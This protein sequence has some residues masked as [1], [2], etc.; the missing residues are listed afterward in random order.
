L[1]QA[2]L[3]RVARFF[4][5]Q[6]TKTGKIYQIKINQMSIKYTKCPHSRQKGRKIDQLDQKIYQHVPLQVRPKFTQIWI[7]FGMKKMPSGK[8]AARVTKVEEFSPL[9]RAFYLLR[10]FLKNMY[11]SS[12]FCW[13]YFFPQII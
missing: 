7:I 8:L 5:V 9:G 1:G 4:I 10:K 6:H 2:L 11:S 12:T 3:G 13:L